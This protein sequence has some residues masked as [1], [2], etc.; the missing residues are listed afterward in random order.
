MSWKH[1]LLQTTTFGCIAD[2]RSPV[3][4]VGIPMDHTGTYKP[5]TRFAP[6]RIR[7]AACNLELYSILADITLEDIGFKDYGDVL[8]PPGDVYRAVDT[9]KYVVGKVREE[10]EKLIVVL[11]GEHLVTYPVVLAFKNSIDTLVVFDA[12]LDMRSEYLSSRL[13]HATFL[14]R[15]I[16]E[17]VRVVHFGSRAYS[18]EELEFVKRSEVEIYSIKSLKKKQVRL[19]QLGKV[20]LSIDIDVFDPSIAPGV[21]NPEPYGIDFDI[22]A[23][24]L[25]E[26]VRNAD[27]IVGFDIVEVNPLVDVNDVTSLLA[28]KVGLEIIGM[29]YK[30]KV[31]QEVK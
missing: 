29:Y 8:L 3:A 25:E 6:S 4:V 15:L 31:P 23:S 19:P 20:Y 28:A 27:D 5:G 9:V 22:F 1:L 30:K 17:D 2:E 18:K 26:I 13:N 7:E 11:G 24:L 21:Q 12:H 14:R 10:H 16:E